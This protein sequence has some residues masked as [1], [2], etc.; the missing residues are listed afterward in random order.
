MD[1]TESAT[2][3]TPLTASD[4]SPAR[5]TAPQEKWHETRSHKAAERTLVGCSGMGTIEHAVYMWS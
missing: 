5:D 1:E 3:A 4:R 2:R